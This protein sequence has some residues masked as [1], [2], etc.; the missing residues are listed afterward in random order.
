M[1]EQFDRPGPVQRWRAIRDQ[2]H[3][4]VCANGYDAEVGAFVQSY[5]SKR[6]DASALLIPLAGFLPPEDDRVRST[7]EVIGRE[8]SC[9]GLIARYQADATNV[10]VDGLPPG[11][12]VF[13]PCSFWYAADLALLGRQAEAEELFRRL[14]GLRNELGLLSEEYDPVAGRM[15]GNF[16]QAF[17]HLALVVSAHVLVRGQPLRD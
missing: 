3:A 1:V 15:L 13:L 10:A 4:D 11:E 14:L 12:G 17:T 16:P 2:I 7:I 5:G 6:L 8:L 9:D